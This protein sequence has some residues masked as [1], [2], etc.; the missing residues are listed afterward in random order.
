MKLDE[1]L[2]QQNLE[3]YRK[4]LVELP[5]DDSRR[6]MLSKLLAEEK[7]KEAA[8]AKIDSR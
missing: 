7:V 5:P 2:R 8:K 1:Y 6:I 4:L 3:L